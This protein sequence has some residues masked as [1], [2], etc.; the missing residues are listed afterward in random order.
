MELDHGIRRVEK[1]GVERRLPLP[2]PRAVS[3]LRPAPELNPEEKPD[4]DEN[5]S[6]EF[7]R[8]W[9]NSM[10]ASGKLVTIQTDEC[11]ITVD[12]YCGLVRRP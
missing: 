1:Q 9:G 4:E 3:L 7:K 8:K 12:L 5:N 6:M 11:T 2:Q 10:K